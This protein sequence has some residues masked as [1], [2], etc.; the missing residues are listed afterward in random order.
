[1]DTASVCVNIGIHHYAE[2]GQGMLEL[3]LQALVVS[4]CILCIGYLWA[5]DVEPWKPELSFI[6]F[7]DSAS[8]SNS[9]IRIVTN[10]PKEVDTLTILE[11]GDILN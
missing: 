2:L 10:T 11:A 7:L 6:D 4:Q 1:M 5:L 9:P 8:L 3:E